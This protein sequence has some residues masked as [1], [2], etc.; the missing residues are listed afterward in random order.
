MRPWA[1]AA[2]E[3][4]RAL[5]LALAE[6]RAS[7]DL[8][9]EAMLLASQGIAQLDAREWDVA[10]EHFQSSI[11]VLRRI[12]HAPAEGAVLG[13]LGRVR[14]LQRRIEDAEGMLER[15]DAV[16]RRS[17]ER[18]A[19][20]YVLSHL[21][22]AQADGGDPARGR[23]TLAKARQLAERVGDPLVQRLV[24]LAAAHIG[25]AEGRAA[26]TEAAD[27]EASNSAR[28]VLAGVA[29]AT[30]S[31]DLRVATHLLRLALRPPGSP[32]P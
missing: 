12:G 20:A 7:G 8:L 22:A 9:A 28:A 31:V 10:G 29:A 5:R 32:G 2:D 26:G 23:R 24:G 30:G 21:A 11:D 25:L 1:G 27:L 15:S 6:A 16:L 3:V 13:Q 19:R 4:D 17:G 14:L 18:R